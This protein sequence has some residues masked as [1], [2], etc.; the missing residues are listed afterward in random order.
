MLTI[1]HN[2]RCA[3]SR[4]ALNI[5]ENSGNMVQV[6]EYL[7]MPPSKD[8]LRHVVEMLGIKPEELVRKNEDLYKT[9]FKGKS[10][11]DEEWLDVL[12]NNPKLIER[13]V[14]IKEKKAII[15]RP[16]EKVKELL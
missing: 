13:P 1:Y 7:K 4:E 9:E 6:V 3:K 16:P 10:L 2:P 5:I 15:A 14:V 11:S 12:A 8:E